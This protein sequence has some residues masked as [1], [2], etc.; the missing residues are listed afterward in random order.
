MPGS[1]VSSAG[2]ARRNGDQ[3]N[4]SYPTH[5]R[6]VSCLGL[7]LLAFAFSSQVLA[8]TQI[9]NC[10][11]QVQSRKRGIAVNSMSAA[12]F[13]AVA[14]GVSWY[15]NWGATPLA[16]PGDVT[17]DFIPIAWN[18]SS[19]YQTSISSYLAAGNRPWRVFAINEPNLT[20]QAGMTP[21]AT[22][23]AFL[24]VKAICDPYN[25][26]VI[27]PHMAAGS[28]PAESITAYDPIQGSNVTY[29]TQE[30]F[31]NAFLYYCGATPPAGMA[32]HMYDV[33]SGAVAGI[34]GQMHTDYPTQK[35]WMTE[36]CPWGATSDAQ[37]LAY[38]VPAVD[39]LERTSWIEGYSWFMARFDNPYNSL[40][41]S[42]S[43]VLTA[44]GQAY[45]QMPVHQ[46]NLYYRIPGRLQAERYVTMNQM[47]IAATTDTNGLADMISAAAGGSVDYNIQ[48]DTA[49]S[50]PLNFR[51]SGA[52]GLI[53]VYQG[54]TLLGTANAT[55]TS[56]ATVSTTVTLAAGTQTLHVVLAANAQQLNWMEFQQVN[57][58]VS[59]PTGVSATATN[60]QVTLS[61]SPAAGATSYNVQRSTTQGGPYTSIASPTTT[62]YT[63]TGLVI[64][65][66]YYYVVSATD[67]INVSSNS[68]EVSA[69]TGSHVNLALNQPVV[70]STWQDGSGQYYCPGS[71]AV[72]G[73]LSTRWASAWTN[74]AWIYVDLGATYNITEVKLTWEAAYATSFQ[75]QVSSNAVNWTTIYST[76][77]GPGGVQDLTGLSGTGRYV[78]MYGT[79]RAT[80]Y[81]YSLWEFEVYGTVPA[82]PTPTGL[83]ATA[84]NQQVS[85][86]WNAVPGATSYN[87]KSSTTNGGPYITIASP[88]TTS[89]TNTSLINDTTYYYV[90]SAVNAGYESTNSTQVSATPVCTPPAAPTAGNN[91]PIWAGTTLNLTASTVSGATYSWTGPNGFT[92]ASQNP[93]IVNA[94]T[95]ASGLYSVTATVGCTSAAGTTTVVVNLIPAPAGLTATASDSLV[96]LSWNPSTAATGYNVKRS[97]VD[98]GPYTMVSGGLTATNYND[99]VVTNGTT[100]YYVVSATNSACESTNSTQVSATPVCMPPAA[101]AGLTATASDSLVVLKWNASSGAI[102]YN[103]KRSLING[104]SYTLLSGGLTDTNC[105][106]SVVTNGTTYYYVVS[107]INAGCESTNSIQAS[108]TPTDLPNHPPVLAAISD[109]TIMAGRTLLVTNSASDPDIPA[110][111]LT[112]SLLTAPA[113]ATI[114]SSSGVFSWRPTMAQ[115][116]S[117]QTVAVVV[118]DNCMPIMSDTQSFTATVTHASRSC[119]QYHFHRQRPVW[120]LDQRR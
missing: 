70:V 109:Q 45:V 51:V 67:G 113:N 80:T 98:G 30:P 91:G 10:D 24:Q 41:T 71:Y 61:W 64:G 115:A 27:A 110:Q 16:K 37:V 90:V 108:A 54:G 89:Y 49:G 111:T 38:M 47:N 112:F 19:G 119:P 69:T 96:A 120:L 32:T 93:S 9:V 87:V 106:D 77:T 23:T 29:T 74:Y 79:V 53:S 59:V 48:V 55:Q 34:T 5:S 100:Y 15:Y 57:G 99:S 8:D 25:I 72:D 118:S 85:L 33:S 94:T 31:I 42:S 75:I 114:N 81:G 4:Q 20:T 39:Y 63:N 104:G 46:T 44:A 28:A 86:S 12:D 117:T 6:L 97:L 78:R 58:P 13:E 73:N 83:T 66:T 26:P 82:P 102:G 11:A 103:V 7:V 60:T 65:T 1:F 101:P 68:I 35:I 17:M 18:G 76:T 40:L 56:W 36:F 92:S 107:A 88:T 50:Y 14:P 84:G 52:I 3:G 116:P 62:S 105:T 21:A 2:M 22:A 95:S 43:G